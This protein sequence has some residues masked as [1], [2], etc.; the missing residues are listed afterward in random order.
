[1][2]HWYD[3]LKIGAFADAYYA[4]NFNRPHPEAAGTPFRA[5]DSNNGFALAWAGL[6][7]SYAKGNF[8]ATVNLRFGPSVLAHNSNDAAYGSQYIKQ[9]FATWKPLG[10]E[11]KLT[12]DMG[13][14]DQPFGSEVAD[15]QFNPNYTRSTLFWMA[16][17]LYF[18]G[19]RVDYAFSSQVDLKLFAVNGWNRVVDNNA[20]KSFGAQLM[21]KPADQAVFY[22]GYMIGGEQPDTAMVA[23]TPTEP[24][25]LT[26]VKSAN[27]RM[28]HFVDVVADINPTPELRLLANGD[29]GQEDMGGDTTAIWYGANLMVSYKLSDKVFVAPRGGIYRDDNYVFVGQKRTLYDVTATLGYVPSPNFVIKLDGRGDFADEAIYPSYSYG[30]FEKSQFTATL[31]VVAMTN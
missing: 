25:V 21:L 15:S 18:T 10:T 12:I 29:Y 2:T 4:F 1:M 6:D 3:D 14:F 5:Y 13:K 17:P 31:G 22:V 19:L 23:P 16:Q 27:K 24:P 9:A 26:P 7:A 30:N 11:G 28:R 8:G 20:T